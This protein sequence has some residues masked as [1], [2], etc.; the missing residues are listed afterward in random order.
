MDT[1]LAAF[2]SLPIDTRGVSRPRTDDDHRARAGDESVPLWPRTVDQAMTMRSTP[3][4]ISSIAFSRRGSAHHCSSRRSL[5]QPPLPYCRRARSPGRSSAASC[6]SSSGRAW[7]S[8][9][10]S[11]CS[12]DA[13]DSAGF[14]VASSIVLA[15]SS[16][17]TDEAEKGA[18][19]I[20]LAGGPCDDLDRRGWTANRAAARAEAN[21]RSR[22][23][24]S[25]G[26]FS[27]A[28]V[29]RKNTLALTACQRMLTRWS[30]PARGPRG[31]LGEEHPPGQRLI[32]AEQEVRH[33]QETDAQ[34]SP[35]G[36]R[37]SRAGS[38]RS[39]QVVTKPL[40]AR[41]TPRTSAPQ[42]AHDPGRRGP[43]VASTAR[44]CPDGDPREICG[45]DRPGSGPGSGSLHRQLPRSLVGPVP[46]RDEHC[47]W[48]KP[49]RG[50]TRTKTGLGSLR[51]GHGGRPG[52]R[53]PQ[54]QRVP[55]A[56]TKS[57]LRSGPPKAQ[58]VHSS[59]G[60]GITSRAGP[61]ARRRRSPPSAVPASRTA[62]SAGS[63]RRR[64]TGG[65]RRR[66]SCRRGRG[67]AP[68]VD[69]VREA[70]STVPSGRRS[71]RQSLR[72]PPTV[73]LL[74][75][76]TK[77]NRSS[78][79]TASPFGRSTSCGRGPASRCLRDRC[80]R[81]P[82]PCRPLRVDDL[83]VAAVAVTRVGEVDAALRNR[84]PGRSAG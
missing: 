22:S 75:S 5:R 68:V 9:S 79:V 72:A 51:G 59:R 17:Q 55:P 58:L 10:W 37:D 62:V 40:E 42:Y 4:A 1:S 83:H 45:D 21:A 7:H 12:A 57:V 2:S 8:A 29:T 44:P 80:G 73:S 20:R 48:S 24:R 31:A 16:A 74:L 38:G 13:L 41:Q 67:S 33:A 47:R 69:Q 6:P 61:R 35:R 25:G 64:R 81:P 26:E 53:T 52:T 34:P 71:N 11:R 66:A 78:R 82:R 14:G 30:P 36:G 77:R 63:G 43:T 76:A 27:S 23:A 46:I 49:R 84:W 54:L 15:L 19:Q 60:I 18:G 39:S 28:R 65:R 3:L 70:S 32:H 56:V 50:P